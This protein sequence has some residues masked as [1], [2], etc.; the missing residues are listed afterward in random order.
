MIGFIISAIVLNN[1]FPGSVLN[2][3]PAQNSDAFLNGNT[4]FSSSSIKLKCEFLGVKFFILLI[5]I[6]K[7][8]FYH[9]YIYYNKKI[10]KINFIDN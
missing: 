2:P 3:K 7:K 10:Y 4:F 9:I 6:I 5:S 8:Q 1:A